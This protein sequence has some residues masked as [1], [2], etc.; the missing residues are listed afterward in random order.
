MVDTLT[1]HGHAVLN[2][3]DEFGRFRINSLME[4]GT[5]ILQVIKR[6]FD[7]LN[8]YD[9]PYCR[10]DISDSFPVFEDRTLLQMPYTEVVSPS[11]ITLIFTPTPYESV[12]IGAKLVDEVSLTD[13]T[14][15]KQTFKESA[16][17][18]ETM[19]WGVYAVEYKY[20][21][22]LSFETFVTQK[23]FPL[24]ELVNFNEFLDVQRGSKAID[25]V[26]IQEIVDLNRS[27]L[28]DAVLDER[29]SV[30][31]AGLLYLRIEEELRCI[32]IASGGAPIVTPK[33][34]FEAKSYTSEIEA[35]AY[36]GKIE[37]G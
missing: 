4:D 19:S 11:E 32:D 17:M 14:K 20:Y 13:Q 28:E 10:H 8:L 27:F 33:A 26:G 16:Q 25:E 36:E 30:N 9:A 24:T 1:E 7:A 6:I 34:V 12:S 15:Q 3:I 35:K 29:I 2:S 22:A 37:V 31:K 5:I 18:N 23:I 21:D